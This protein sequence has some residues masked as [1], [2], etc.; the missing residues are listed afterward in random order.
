MAAKKNTEKKV[1][2]NKLDA[3]LAAEKAKYGETKVTYDIDGEDIDI[4]V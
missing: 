1:S 2:I 3:L 4:L